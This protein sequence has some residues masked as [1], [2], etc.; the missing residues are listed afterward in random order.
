MLDGKCSGGARGERRDRPADRCAFT[1]VELLVVIAVIGVLVTMLVPAVNLA[2]ESSRKAACQS[3]LRQFGLGMQVYADQKNGLYCSGAFDWLRDGS[4]TDLGWVA[5]LVNQGIPVGQM[6]CPSNTGQIAETF[7]DLLTAPPTPDAC[8]NRLGSEPKALPDGTEEMNPCR[9][10]ITQSM[11]PNSDARRAL[12]VSD[13][14]DKDYNTNYTASWL[15][16]RS[17]P[18]LDGSGNVVSRQVGCA[19]SLMSRSATAGPLSQQVLDSAKIAASSV[20]FLG[21]GTTTG[22]LSQD[23]GDFTLGTFV[24]QSFTVGPLLISTGQK[25]S[26]SQGTGRNGADGWWAVWSKQTLQDYRGF[27]PVHRSVC[28]I[29]MADGS[30]RSFQDENN[31]GYLNNGLQSGANVAGA[32]AALELPTEEVFSG[33]TLRGL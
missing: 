10:I 25:P 30:V 4:V 18:L 6:L 15:L 8:V 13:I 3:N 5:D 22:S 7:N 31:D 33:A 27:A 9:Q 29:L 12:I 32:T 11:D 1:L 20:P 19:S 21:C 24:T 16:V 14:L 17:R 28:N 26:F 2:R 23:L